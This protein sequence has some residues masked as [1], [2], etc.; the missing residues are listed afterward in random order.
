MPPAPKQLLT[1]YEM[2]IENANRLE[3]NSFT[4]HLSRDGLC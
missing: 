4:N 3:T 1:L 2:S